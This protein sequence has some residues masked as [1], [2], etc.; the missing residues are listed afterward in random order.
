MDLC[1]RDVCSFRR[2]GPGRTQDKFRD[3]QEIDDTG[4]SVAV[5]CRETAAKGLCCLVRNLCTCRDIGREFVVVP[6]VH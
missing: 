1:R 5:T 2:L 3:A 4:D 6:L